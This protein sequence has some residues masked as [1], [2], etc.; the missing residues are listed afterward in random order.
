MT[1]LA[2]KEYEIVPACFKRSR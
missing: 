1:S 2:S